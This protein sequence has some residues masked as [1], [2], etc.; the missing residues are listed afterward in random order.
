MILSLWAISDVPIAKLRK[1]YKKFYDM[2][3]AFQ[4]TCSKLFDVNHYCKYAKAGLM[5]KFYS[6][7]HFELAITIFA[8][9]VLNINVRY[10]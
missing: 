2:I 1:Y 9:I 6:I 7:Q 8:T 10:F 4:P 5:K 3:Q